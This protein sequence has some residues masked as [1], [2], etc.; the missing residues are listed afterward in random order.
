MQHLC[1]EAGCITEIFLATGVPGQQDTDLAVGPGPS[2]A[3]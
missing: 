1:C 3:M 2:G